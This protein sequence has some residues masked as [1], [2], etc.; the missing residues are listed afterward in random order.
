MKTIPDPI[1]SFYGLEENDEKGRPCRG[2]ACFVAR[3]VN[4]ERWRE[5]CLGRALYCLGQCFAAPAAPEPGL[6]PLIRSDART[7]VVLEGLLQGPCRTV[8]DYK[9]RG[10][11]RA[12]E[13]A[14]GL[15]PEAILAEVE[16]SGLRGR[17]GAG[18]STGRKWR[19]VAQAASA[20]GDKFVVA[21]A[22]EGDPGAYIDRFLMEDDP[23][24]LIEAM[25]IAA[26]AVGATKGLIYLRQEYPAARSILEGALEEA[27]RETGHPIDLELVVGRGS[28]VCG[29]ETAL[30]RSIEDERPEVL[31]RPPYP[32]ERGLLDRPT[33]VNNVE[34]LASIPWIVQNGGAAYHAMGIGKSR[35]TK[36]VSLNSLF[37][38]PGLYEVEFGLP[39]RR[40][41]EDLGGGLAEGAIQGLLIGGPLAGVLPPSLFETPF[42]FEELA[43]AGA[44]VGHGGVVAFDERTSLKDLILH[45]FA[46]AADESCGKCTPCRLGSRRIERALERGELTR[47]D[48]EDIVSALGRTSLCG[49]GGGLAEFA[50]SLSRHYPK[51]LARC[52][53]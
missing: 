23:F 3:H 9:R 42:A 19:M 4:P 43:A 1:A 47:A 5:A 51:E 49:L 13:R 16:A 52:L 33:L 40:I 50:K 45:V 11:F 39:V 29:E 34:T 22:D 2:A 38:R 6:R 35:G 44:A 53:A 7:T 41:V 27:R 37:R 15:G 10:G 21:N 24:R 12:L 28:Y 31:A 48:W 30:I 8:R 14:L 17:G 26:C 32:T 20:D 18:F 36:A 46:F 25:A